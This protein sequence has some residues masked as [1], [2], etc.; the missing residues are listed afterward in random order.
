[1]IIRL[2]GADFSASNIGNLYSWNINYILGRGITHSGVTSVLKGNAYNV[3]F[4]LMDGYEL[5]T[6]G[7]SVTMGG[8]LLSADIITIAD[9]KVAIEIAEVTG[10]VIINIPT[11]TSVVNLIDYSTMS[12]TLR[13]SPGGYNIVGS[14]GTKYGLL[15]IRLKPNT[16]YNLKISSGYTGGL[17]NTEPIKGT[18]TTADYGLNAS[19]SGTHV[20]TTTADYYWIAINVATNETSNESTT[21]TPNT[22]WQNAILWEVEQ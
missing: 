20:I 9:N 15:V 21:L 14:S 8:V 16:T 12:S 4:T 5:T 11:K 19:G 22:I 3:T 18:K 1:M 7:I 10:P 6:D 13:Y 2:K 17:F